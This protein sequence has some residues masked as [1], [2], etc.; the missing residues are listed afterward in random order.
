MTVPNLSLS[1]VVVVTALLCVTPADLFA[2]T[3][4]GVETPAGVVDV[5]ILTHHNNP[6]RTGANTQEI[7][8]TAEKVKSAEF[9]K[10]WEYPVRGR[11]YAQ[12]LYVTLKALSQC[13]VYVA[14][15]ENF[16]YAFDAESPQLIWRY[17]A[18][19]DNVALSGRV[20]TGEAGTIEE[21]AQNIMPAIG[22]IGTPV[23]DL[24]HFTMYLVA[25][26]QE[27]D[28]GHEKFF[29]T[30]HAVDIRTGKLRKKTVITGPA[31][32]PP[33]WFYSG[34]QNQRAALALV[35]DRVYIAWAGFADIRPYDGLVMSYGTMESAQP[36]DKLDQFQV[37]HGGFQS[38]GG[39]GIWHS[40]GGPAV[41]DRGNFVYVVTGNGDSTLLAD[42]VGVNFDSSTVKLSLDLHVVDYY[43]PSYRSLLN[44]YDLDLSVSGPVIPEDQPDAQGRPVKLLLHGS[45]TGFLYVLNRDNLGKS[46]NI[47]Q[48]LPVFDGDGFNPKTELSHHIHTVPVYWRAPA[49]PRVYVASDYNLGVRA[50][51]FLQEKLD[52][53]P[54]ASN[55]F[56][57]A[58]ISQMSLSSNGSSPGTGI[59]WFISSPTGTVASYPAIL[60]AFDAETLEMLYSSETNPFD[61][62]GD[63]P[64]FNAPTIANGKVYVP[65][66]SNKLVV[67]GLC[68][69]TVG[70]AYEKPCRCKLCPAGP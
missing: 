7:L 21:A 51:R 38:G 56:P 17:D 44:A 61:R 1:T 35:D 34:R 60:Y 36:L 24:D 13:L 52:P 20:Y 53:H 63:Y 70:A 14:T 64:R 30:L 62:L 47:I 45:K 9:G 18:G 23:I 25:M 57:R 43:T 39:G 58:P 15:A 41:D 67:Y 11:I 19:S 49:G 16:V 37:A 31:S 29:H 65:T 6:Q 12:P 59:L 27:G 2:Q 28:E 10:L 66:F 54:V 32:A 22:I 46:D 33:P 3:R 55:L 40:G 42:F 50:F 26:T 68:P 48:A 69:S 4:C 8:L 5:N